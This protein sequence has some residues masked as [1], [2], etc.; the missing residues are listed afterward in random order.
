MLPPPLKLKLPKLNSKEQSPTTKILTTL[1]M[2]NLL[3]ICN[4]QEPVD[5]ILLLLPT[6]RLLTGEETTLFK[7]E[8]LLLEETTDGHLQIIPI[9]HLPELII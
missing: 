6:L 7:K 2:E 3:L 5:K 4:K 1:S 9:G 8:M